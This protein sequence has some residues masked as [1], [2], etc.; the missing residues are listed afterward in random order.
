ML[1]PRLEGELGVCSSKHMQRHADGDHN[2]MFENSKGFS[3]N[4]AGEGVLNEW[5]EMYLRKQTE[6]S[7]GSHV[8]S[9]GS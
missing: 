4:A 7:G 6:S 5:Q 1:E 2:S 8:P 9:S 3:S